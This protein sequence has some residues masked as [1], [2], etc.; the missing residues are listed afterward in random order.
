MRVLFFAL[1][2]AAIASGIAQPFNDQDRFGKSY[3]QVAAYKHADWMAWYCD[4]T[5]AGDGGKVTAE[6]IYAIALAYQN[7]SILES[8]PKAER[9]F[10]ED[11]Q[12]KFANMAKFAFTISHA[13]HGDWDGLSLTTAETSTGINR[14]IQEMILSRPQTAKPDMAKV[15]GAFAA[16]QK[17]L[18]ALKLS[19]SDAKYVRD[20]YPAMGKMIEQ[21][22]KEFE[23][24]P[25]ADKAILH[26]FCIYMIQVASLDRSPTPSL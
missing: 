13:G 5:R 10:F 22:N 17:R 26:R 6:K 16:G 24:R 9:D 7:Q 19:E 11:L 4:A 18:D 2:L 15:R 1:L 20:H 12:V 25:P 21:L 3:P 14:S 8:R 23:S